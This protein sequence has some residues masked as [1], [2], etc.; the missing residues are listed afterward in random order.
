MDPDDLGRGR[1]GA[2]YAALAALLAAALAVLI[3]LVV[4]KVPDAA[5]GPAPAG[6]WRPAPAAVIRGIPP[7][8][9]RRLVD[10]QAAAEAACQD[11]PPHDD[12]LASIDT[13]EAILAAHPDAHLLRPAYDTADSSG[14]PMHVDAVRAPLTGWVRVMAAEA[15]VICPGAPAR[16]VRR[17]LA[18]LGG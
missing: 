6:E 18:R 15:R 5:P 13:V 17:A 11:G 9:H 12:L 7:A 3:W 1:P 10:A 4:W 16:R 2:L 14:Q 8:E